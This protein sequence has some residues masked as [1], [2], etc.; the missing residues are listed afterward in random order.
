MELDINR[1]SIQQTKDIIERLKIK[2]SKLDQ[3][4]QLVN[5]KL[6]RKGAYECVYDQLK[7]LNTIACKL[8]RAARLYHLFV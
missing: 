1:S 7:E 6:D 3:R 4:L 2:C 5:N 8:Q